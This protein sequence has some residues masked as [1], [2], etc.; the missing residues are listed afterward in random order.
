MLASVNFI[1]SGPIWYWR[2]PAPFYFISVPADESA[3]IKQMQKELSYGWG[4]ITVRAKIGATEFKT[5]L[6][7]KDGLYSLPVKDAVREAEDLSEGDSPQV[8]L[9]LG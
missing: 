5:A 3:Q 2:G 9:W 6:I 7:P 8:Q 1:F 4:C